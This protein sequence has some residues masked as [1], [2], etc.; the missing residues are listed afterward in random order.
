MK[1]LN[2]L[3]K[4]LKLLKNKKT[5]VGLVNNIAA[6]IE[7]EDLVKNLEFNTVLDIGSNKGQFILLVEKLF[8][9]DKFFYSFEPINEVLKKQKKFFSSKKNIIFFNFAL[10]K[11]SETK[12][13][14]I[15]KR[16]DSSSFLEI[17]DL[18]KNT[19]YLIK[20][21]R[22][23]EI[24]ALDKIIKGENLIKPILIKI[25]VQGYEFEVLKGAGNILR[26]T[27]YIIIEVSENEIYKGQSLTNE[28]INYL[29]NFNFSST[30]ETEFYQIPGTKFKQKDILFIN[31]NFNE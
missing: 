29:E 23:I 21:K 7:L 8:E 30:N 13:F 3:I 10:G 5:R 22:S 17:N 28:I 16:I 9:N 1:I 4:L 25:D 14:N 26:Q 20:E 27:K 2:K 31:R 12:I 18:V 6:N 24:R 15:T 19:D 11:E